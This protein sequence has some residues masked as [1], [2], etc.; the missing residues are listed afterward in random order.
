MLWV[1]N[2]LLKDKGTIYTTSTS[3]ECSGKLKT[4][5]GFYKRNTH[6]VLRVEAVY[7]TVLLFKTSSFDDLPSEVI[8]QLNKI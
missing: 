6:V 2:R 3:F 1:A 4:Q 5:I 8:I 7:P